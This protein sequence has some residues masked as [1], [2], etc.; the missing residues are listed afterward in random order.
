MIT[1][2]NGFRI[3]ENLY[4]LTY[5]YEKYLIHCA[6]IINACLEEDLVAV[7][8]VLPAPYPQGASLNLLLQPF[9]ISSKLYTYICSM[10]MP[11]K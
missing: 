1:N 2:M 7:N 5:S 9:Q 11:E 10:N 6:L 3:P 8:K 4:F